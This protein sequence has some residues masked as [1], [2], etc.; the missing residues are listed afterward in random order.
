MASTRGRRTRPRTG[1]QG[2]QIFLS[3]S[4]DDA[5]EASL[6]QYAIEHMFVTQNV[7]VWTY[8]RD[9]ARDQHSIGKSL[10]DRVRESSATIFLVSPSTLDAGAAQWME[11]AYADAYDVPT[12]VILHRLTFAELKGR[13]RGVPPLLLESQCNASADWKSVVES[14]RSRIV[15]APGSGSKE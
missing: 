4:G 1:S 5:F 8:Q 13:K 7:T 9:Q 14:L 6:L 12:F 3:Y 2:A 10:K 11:L 15:G